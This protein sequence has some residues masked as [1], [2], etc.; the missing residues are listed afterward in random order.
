MAMAA[1]STPSQRPMPMGNGPQGLSADLYVEK[2][3]H[4]YKIKSDM[5]VLNPTAVRFDLRTSLDLPLA[6]IVFTE[7]KINYALY[8]D[9][10]F[11]SGRPGPHALDPVFPLSVDVRTLVEI[12]EEKTIR[13][14]Q[15]NS[16]GEM[17]E[18]RG[19]AGN[20]TYV[21]TWSKY[22]NSGP[23]AGRSSK[24]VLELPDRQVSL[25]FYLNDWQREVPN[26][27]RLLSLQVPAGF[28]TLSTP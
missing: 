9:K 10:K 11:Y 24:I 4:S 14:A 1:C 12:L 17:K 18:C 6:S 26:A 21:V 15:C 20:T 13:G 25:R 28:A 27:E 3:G 16:D 5:I 19:Q 23:L 7:Q 22:K 2:E 8:R